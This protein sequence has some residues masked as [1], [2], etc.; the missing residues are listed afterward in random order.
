MPVTRAEVGTTLTAV[1]AWMR[2][3]AAH[4]VGPLVAQP[5]GHLA[6]AADQL[7]RGPDDVALADGMAPCPPGPVSVM[8]SE[9]A[10]DMAMPA[11]RATKPGGQLGGDV[12]AD[13]PR[14]LHGG[15]RAALRASPWRRTAPPRPAG[16]GR[17]SGR[18]GPRAVPPSTEAAPSREA[19][20][21]SWPQA[22]MM[23]ST[24]EWTGSRLV[25]LHR[26]AVDVAPQHDGAAP[27]GRPPW[28]RCRRSRWSAAPRRSRATPCGRG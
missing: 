16:R 14:A 20:W 12:E 7:G 27:A 23:P 13:E 26:Q 4:A 21:T 25:L 19:T 28:R 22:C 1:P 9:W 11:R 24:S 5:V 2:A 8:R 18:G 17:R 10:S 6:Q 15:Q 3:G